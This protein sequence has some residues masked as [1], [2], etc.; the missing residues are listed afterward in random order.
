MSSHSCTTL[1]A[2]GHHRGSNVEHGSQETHVLK[3]ASP[4]Q[5]THDGVADC[6]TRCGTIVHRTHTVQK[7]HQRNHYL[8]E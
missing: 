2:A 1:I 6:A 7:K 4:D 3:R 8:H 5:H